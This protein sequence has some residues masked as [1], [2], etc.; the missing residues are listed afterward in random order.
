[1]CCNQ[2]KINL[3]FFFQVHKEST[4]SNGSTTVTE[5]KVSQE[6]R[7][8]HFD[9]SAL[10][11]QHAL[12]ATEVQKKYSKPHEQPLEDFLDREEQALLE[13]K[14]KEEEDRLYKEFIE[15]RTREEKR[16][17]S[18]VQEEWEVELEKL[19]QK[20]EKEMGKKRGNSEDLKLLTIKHNK[21]KDEVKK[22]L[23]IKREKKKESV[24]RKLLEQ[25]RAATAALVEKHS[26]EMMH[27]IQEKRAQ[28]TEINTETNGDL[29]TTSEYPSQPPRP[30]TPST[31]Q[32]HPTAPSHTKPP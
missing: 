8:G 20:F 25:E 5:H 32:P 17:V 30:A 4:T 1:M 6:H 3:D 10:H 2:G 14:Q 24:Q 9:S 27:L 11:I 12:K 15:Q 28:F 7:W 13:A 29:Q 23:T 19:T 26:Q 22:N 21:E 16:V 18:S 31:T